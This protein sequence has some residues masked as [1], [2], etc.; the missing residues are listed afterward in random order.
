MQP[1]KILENSLAS[2]KSLA[3]IAF[4]SRPLTKAQKPGDNR[5]IIIMGNGPSLADNLRK[6]LDLLQT[7]PAMAVNYA[8]LTPEFDLVRPQYYILA[9]PHFFTEGASEN[10]RLLCG[11]MR[12]IECPMTLFVPAMYRRKARRL[13][14]K[15]NIATYNGIGVEGFEI[16]THT[17]FSAGLGMPRPRNVLIPAIMVA[18]SLGFKEIVLLGADHSWTKTL[19]VNDDNEVVSI[20]PHFYAE[21]KKEEERIRHDYRNIRIHTV[22]ESFSIAFRSYHHIAAYARKRGVTIINAT[23]GSFIDAFERRSVLELK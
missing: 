8:A 7:T 20:Q 18:I 10:L 1:V 11:R 19:S 12:R 17:A 23:P 4:Q 5:R 2:L 15:V 16:L 14:P 22:L 21:S 9:D 13:Y 6:D 3:K